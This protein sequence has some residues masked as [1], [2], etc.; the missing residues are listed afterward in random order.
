MGPCAK[1][2]VRA[3]RAPAIAPWP[4]RSG[5]RP[6]AGTGRGRKRIAAEDGR[7]TTRCPYRCKAMLE[8]IEALATR[9]PEQVVGRQRAVAMERLE[10]REVRVA[11][12]D[13]PAEWLRWGEPAS[14]SQGVDEVAWIL[15]THSRPQCLPC[16]RVLEAELERVFEPFH[17]VEGSRGRDTGG[18]GLGLTIARSV[19]QLHAGTLTLRNID[20]GGL[21]AT[22]TLPRR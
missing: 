8:R 17:R 15:T 5:H 12:F 4:H 2:A 11:Y 18:T 19:A 21:E 9:E 22:L 1:R 6:C 13:A 20:G 3:C 14:T 16:G 10:H 7:D